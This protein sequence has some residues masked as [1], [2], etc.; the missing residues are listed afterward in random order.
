MASRPISLVITIELTYESKVV[1]K[2]T[3]INHFHSYV[4]GKK[5]DTV[6][7]VI[8][9][10]VFESLHTTPSHYLICTFKEEQ[11]IENNEGPWAHVCASEKIAD[12]HY[13][14]DVIN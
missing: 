12:L 7:Y 1:L 11:K 5:Y 6:I 9:N 13:L 4:G 14:H 8:L 2:Y 10:R 3:D